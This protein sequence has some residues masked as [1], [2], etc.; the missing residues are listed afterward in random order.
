V[1]GVQPFEELVEAFQI[2]G[3]VRQAGEQI[4]LGQPAVLAFPS[5]D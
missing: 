1:R 2:E 3:A 4:V 5:C